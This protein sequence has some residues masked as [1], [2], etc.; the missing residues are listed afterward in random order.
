MLF[1]VLLEL[2]EREDDPYMK[3]SGAVAVDDR[4]TLRGD[5]ASLR[6]SRTKK[7]SRVAC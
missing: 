2:V 7:R 1:A 5:V 4:E 6:L 3:G